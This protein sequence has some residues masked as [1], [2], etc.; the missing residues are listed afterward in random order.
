MTIVDPMRVK[1]EMRNREN[2]RYENTAYQWDMG[3]I[4]KTDTVYNDVPKVT[5]KKQNLNK[6]RVDINGKEM[7]AGSTNYYLHTW[8][9]DQ[10]KGLKADKET[11]AK[12][13]FFV[14]DYP[15][16]VVD[17]IDSEVRVFVEEKTAE[18]VKETPVSG[19]KV[20]KYASL[21]EAPEVVRNALKEAGYKVN[22]AIQILDPMKV[23]EKMS[24]I[25]GRYEYSAFQIDFGKAQA[26]EI[27]YNNIPKYSNKKEVKVGDKDV[28]NSVIELNQTFTYVLNGVQVP[29]DRADKLWDYSF[30]DDYQ[31][32]HDLYEGVYNL[33]ASVDFELQ[34][35]NEKGEVTDT[36]KVKKGDNLNKYSIH[37]F[38]KDKGIVT[39]EMTKEFYDM[40]DNSQPF[41]ADLVLTMKRIASG[42]VENTFENT[43]N[44]V[45]VK[46]NTVK[47]TTPEPKVPEKPKK[48]GLP[49]T[50]TKAS[51]ALISVGL[52]GMLA[53]I[54]LASR[55]RRED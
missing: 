17:I 44:G 1:D 25:G 41:G 23:K 46:S 28:N 5:P 29:A 18:G 14:D 51:T 2:T 40:L 22:G 42:E 47:T 52:A 3:V 34:V 19:I 16:D 4:A 36:I 6:A 37:T 53:A 54:G 20:T 48:P 35:R 24:N 7:L 26:T 32:S 21:E 33:I 13:M 31:E 49:N 12:G 27:V 10:Y 30:K 8:D 9:L 55:K 45:V 11:I 50:G 43:V 39:V 38:D 15:E